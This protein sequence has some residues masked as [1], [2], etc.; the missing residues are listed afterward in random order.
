[1]NWTLVLAIWG[2]ILSTI[3]AIVKILEYR[4]ERA[5]VKVTVMGNYIME[6]TTR[7]YGNRPLIM[8]T[9]ANRGRRPATLVGAAMLL[10]QRREYLLCA[11][12]M[13]AARPIELTEGKSH[14]YL[15]FED[16]VKN[17]YGLQPEKYVR[18]FGMPPEDI[19]GRTIFSRGF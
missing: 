14:Q 10:P 5:N 17:K 15:M 3:L 11:D 1:M 13:T 4:K 6:P 19:I 9:A 2:S 7:A 16:N 12:S 8:I 18:V